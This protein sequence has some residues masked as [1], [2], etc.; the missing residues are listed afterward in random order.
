MEF[1]IKRT[2]GGIPC[3][4]A[5]QKFNP[6]VWVVEIDSLGKLL[7]LVAREERVIIKECGNFTKCG[8]VHT[9]WELEI[10]DD[11]REWHC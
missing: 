4:N 5:V 11:Y 7:D 8:W 1:T 2:S 10:Y 6:N 3:E 9:G